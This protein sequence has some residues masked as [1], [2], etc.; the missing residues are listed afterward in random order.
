[1]IQ[2]C[3]SSPTSAAGRNATSSARTSRPRL[4]HGD[5]V[6][7]TRHNSRDTARR[8]QD[9]AELDDDSKA[10]AR[11]PTN[12]SAWPARIRWPVD[13]T[14]RKLRRALDQSEDDRGEEVGTASSYTTPCRERYVAPVQRGT[15]TLSVTL[16]LPRMAFEYGQRFV[17]ST[18]QAP[19][20]RCA[21]GEARAGRGQPSGRS[22]R[23]RWD[24]FLPA[25]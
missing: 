14:G 7:H 1:V 18:H 24:R 2:W 22:R 9:G 19:R 8:R 17:R 25:R 15:S 21:T 10:A 4:R 3:V 11:G 5:A 13:E 16:T 12:P 6:L 23:A 20:R